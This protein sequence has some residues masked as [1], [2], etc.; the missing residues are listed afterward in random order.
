[1]TMAEL[2]T[3]FR[4]QN[5]YANCMIDVYNN[6]SPTDIGVKY[7]LENTTVVVVFRIIMFYKHSMYLKRF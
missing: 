3:K 2:E 7:E 4:T 5:D 6:A 1:M